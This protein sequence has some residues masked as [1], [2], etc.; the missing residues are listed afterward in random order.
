MRQ[1]RQALLTLAADNAQL[2]EF[3]KPDAMRRYHEFRLLHEAGRAI[4]GQVRYAVPRP[5]DQNLFS[6]DA[7]LFTNGWVNV[8]KDTEL[9]FLCMVADLQA[10]TGWLR[11]RPHSRR[12]PHRILRSGH[13]RLPGS[14]SAPENWSDTDHAIRGSAP[15]RNIQ[16]TS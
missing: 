1:V 8:L 4:G 10:R 11:P 9:A 12:D 2:I 6:L 7:R 3:T 5:T 15:E 14:P 13:R 16:S